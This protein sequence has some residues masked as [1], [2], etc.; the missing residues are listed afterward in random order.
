MHAKTLQSFLTLCE[1]VDCSPQGSSVYGDSPC[2]NMGVGCHFLL[3][4]IFQTQGSNPHLLFP[5]LAG[6]FFTTSA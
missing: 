1:P 2:K 5:A 6:E 4:G 3:Q